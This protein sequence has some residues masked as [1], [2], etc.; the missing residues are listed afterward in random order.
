MKL[1]SPSL[2]RLLYNKCR[3]WSLHDSNRNRESTVSGS[4]FVLF[5]LCGYSICNLLYITST[6]QSSFSYR[7]SQIATL[8]TA[9]HFLVAYNLVPNDCCI[10]C[11]PPSVWS[12]AN[13]KGHATDFHK[14]NAIKGRP[15][16]KIKAV[17]RIPDLFQWGV[18]QCFPCGVTRWCNISGYIPS[19]NTV[20]YGLCSYYSS[21]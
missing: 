8:E 15:Y 16:L 2:Q 19:S 14:R 12:V 6:G 4:F 21:E 5:P 10:C 1:Y 13:T 3:F 18:T 9:Q 7:N 11:M 17:N 20:N